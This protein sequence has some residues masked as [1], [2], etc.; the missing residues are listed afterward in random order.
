MATATQIDIHIC[1]IV[2]AELA[3]GY[4][5]NTVL[6]ASYMSRPFNLPTDKK[7]FFDSLDG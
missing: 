2:H 6:N 5:H 7:A 4:N 1:T 3:A